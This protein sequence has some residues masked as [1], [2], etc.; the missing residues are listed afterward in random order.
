M[1]LDDSILSLDS[2]LIARVNEA[3]VLAILRVHKEESVVV[4]VVES[5]A[6]LP[7]LSALAT[8]DSHIAPDVN[9]HTTLRTPD[10]AAIER[11]LIRKSAIYMMVLICNPSGNTY[12][13]YN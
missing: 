8:N 11:V 6:T 5:S 7:V 2:R 9:I 10:V 4:T 13:F 12:I 3:M 1:G